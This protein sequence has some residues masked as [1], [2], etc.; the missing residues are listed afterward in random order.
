MKTNY[1][2]KF[3]KD[4]VEFRELTNKFYN[5]ELRMP[6]YKHISGGFGSYGERG[7]KLGML[8]LR[9]CGG[10]VTKDYLQFIVD[11]INK[12]NINLIH[13]TTCQCVQL[14]NLSADVICTLIEEAWDHGI[15]TRGGGGD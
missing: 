7:G 2:D 9:H 13:L 8:R 10:R 14:H 6:E 3:R 5:G 15:I 1:A 12:Y 11:S 4:L